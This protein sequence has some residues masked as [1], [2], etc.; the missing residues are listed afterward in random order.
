VVDLLENESEGV[1]VWHHDTEELESVELEVIERLVVLL[2]EEHDLHE[3]DMKRV[4]EDRKREVR[5]G[6]EVWVG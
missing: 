3:E 2:R 6:L 5:E 4:V 1:G